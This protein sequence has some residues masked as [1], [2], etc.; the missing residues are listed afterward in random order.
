MN[1]PYYYKI[2]EPV[3][4][5]WENKWQEGKIVEGYRTFDGIINVQLLNG[6]NIW[7]SEAAHE[8]YLKPIPTTNNLSDLNKNESKELD[9]YIEEFITLKAYIETFIAQ[10]NLDEDEVWKKINE[11][12]RETMS[13]QHG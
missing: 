8:E 2:D 6:E 10:H 12:Y 5:K 9:K 7:F 13:R 4:V 3:L 1:K 11:D